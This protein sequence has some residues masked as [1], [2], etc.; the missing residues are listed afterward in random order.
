MENNTTKFIGAATAI[1][2]AGT[3]F[4]IVH[5]SIP[6][7]VNDIISKQSAV[8]NEENSSSQEKNTNKTSK[9]S[10][11]SFFMNN[12]H[13]NINTTDQKS[14]QDSDISVMLDYNKRKSNGDIDFNANTISPKLYDLINST[15][16]VTGDSLMITSI[17][18]YVL[19]DNGDPVLFPD[20]NDIDTDQTYHV[21]LL[22]SAITSNGTYRKQNL[23]SQWINVILSGSQLKDLYSS[24]QPSS[25]ST[26]IYQKNI[27]YD[28]NYTKKISEIKS[29]ADDNGLSDSE[30]SDMITKSSLSL[31]QNT[32]NTLSIPDLQKIYENYKWNS[33]F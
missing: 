6:A 17:P 33:F 18:L 2:I 32:D 19:D 28:E 5:A 10:A 20:K 7:S 30:I 12:N 31:L 9:L 8:F 3:L 14:M 26:S 29:T 23:E 1:V 4:G 13:T 27:N 21:G 15:K 25:F 24:L 16:T 22:L 11:Y